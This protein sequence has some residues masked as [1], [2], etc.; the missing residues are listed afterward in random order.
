[1]FDAVESHEM[2]KRVPSGFPADHPMADLFRYKDI[3]FGRRLTDTEVRSASLP[4]IIA[5]DYAAAMPVFRFLATL[6]G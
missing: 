3:V 4:D 1:M 5:D 6:K 2:L